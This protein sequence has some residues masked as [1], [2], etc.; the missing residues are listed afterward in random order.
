[1][2]LKIARFRILDEK[3]NI[4]DT[5]MSNNKGE[6]NYRVLC[7]KIYSIQASKDGFEGNVFPVAKSKGPSARVDAALQ[8][9]DVIITPD[10]IVLK[11]IFFE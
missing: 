4:V 2:I 11:P 9:I 1:M 8:P 5:Q 3:N 10:E 7:D 6:V